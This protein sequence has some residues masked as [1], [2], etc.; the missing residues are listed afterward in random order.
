MKE[1]LE[2]RKQEIDGI[3]KRYLPEEEAGTSALAAAMRYSV[4]VGGKRLRPI[5]ML[6][7]YRMFG[8]EDAAIDPFLAAIEMIHP[9][10]LVHDDL[11]ALDNVE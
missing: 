6:E 1:E 2:K 8:G 5:I 11:P 10:S 7:S 3:L 9:H 4:L